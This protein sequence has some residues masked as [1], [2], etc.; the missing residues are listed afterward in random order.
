MTS[1][2]EIPQELW[3]QNPTPGGLFVTDFDG[4]LLRSDRTFAE[5]DL[6]A[7]KKLGAMNI[8]R[9]IATG[10]SIYSFNTVV[11]SDLPV[12]FVIFSTGA[13]VSHFH[14]GQI[15]RKI[16]LEDG[17]VK[18]ATDVLLAARLDFMIHRPI[19]DNHHFSYVAVNAGNTDFEHR[20]SLYEPYAVEMKES[21]D[22]FGPATQLLAVLP[23]SQNMVILDEL[24]EKLSDFNVIQTTSPLDGKSTWIEIFPA[25]VS[26][27]QTAEWL[28]MEL[29]VEPSNIVSLGNDYNDIDLLEWSTDRYVVENAPA[30]LKARFPSVASNNNC[31]VAEAVERWLAR[32]GTNF[33]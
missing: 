4:T 6:L 33:K 26:K 7:L 17:E 8:I 23:P 27:S 14:S 31:G 12:D 9:V 13:G 18:R 10:R 28:A 5:N 25:N 3:K 32:P 16:S 15:V 29:N 1:S 21:A 24:R 2:Q 19:P 30:D 20:I 11:G 22:G